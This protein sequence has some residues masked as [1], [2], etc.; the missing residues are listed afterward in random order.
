M[1]LLDQETTQIVMVMLVKLSVRTEPKYTT[2]NLTRPAQAVPQTWLTDSYR[3]CHELLGSLGCQRY[4]KHSHSKNDV[5]VSA[6]FINSIVLA[7][8]ESTE[9]PTIAEK[10]KQSK[11]KSS[12][13]IN[14]ESLQAQLEA[15][16]KQL[17]ETCHQ[18][19]QT[20]E[21]L[22]QQKNQLME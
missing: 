8:Q 10:E 1:C 13:K 11:S 21:S 4:S 2:K 12:V 17:E 19:E 22:R 20:C 9:S 3:L 15:G 7:W 16:C 18:M 5:K 14:A 6:K